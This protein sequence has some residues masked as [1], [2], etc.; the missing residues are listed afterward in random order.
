MDE[1]VLAP[2]ATAPHAETKMRKIPYD[3]REYFVYQTRLSPDGRWIVFEAVANSPKVESALHVM[4]VE[5]AWTRITDGQHWDDKPRSSPDGKAIYFV[6]FNCRLQGNA[7]IDRVLSG[8]SANRKLR[9]TLRRVFASPSGLLP[10]SRSYG[11]NT[12]LG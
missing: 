10:V 2:D 11:N 5:G 6:I 1:I 12:S 3:H 7:L 9:G 4:P 8:L